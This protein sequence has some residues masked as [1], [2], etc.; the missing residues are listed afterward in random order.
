LTYDAILSNIHMVQSTIPIENDMCGCPCP[1]GWTN[2][3]FEAIQGNIYVSKI[4]VKQ[5]IYWLHCKPTI[6]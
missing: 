1:V 3:L 2:T 4:V 5:V 6:F